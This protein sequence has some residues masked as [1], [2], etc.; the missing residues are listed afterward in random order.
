MMHTG[1]ESD[2]LAASMVQRFNSVVCGPARARASPSRPLVLHFASSADIDRLMP[3]GGRTIAAPAGLC[4]GPGI[5]WSARIGSITYGTDEDDNA[6]LSNATEPVLTWTAPVTALKAA[7]GRDGTPR[8]LAVV[9]VA[10][11]RYPSPAWWPGVRAFDGEGAPPTKP[12]KRLAPSRDWKAPKLSG[13][14][15]D[16]YVLLNGQRLR[17]AAIPAGDGRQLLVDVTKAS[18]PVKVGDRVCLVC[19]ERPL[20][21][22]SDEIGSDDY[23]T[24]RCL[25]GDAPVI[26]TSN[27]VPKCKVGGAG[28]KKKP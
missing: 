10:P 13:Y 28:D 24:A 23:N 22:L 7:T 3:K 27:P 25:A 6:L 1:G 26:G 18:R 2:A 16:S 17:L 4:A 19:K 8:T 20:G 14:K 9:D 15:P 21:L 5:S 12:E 11:A